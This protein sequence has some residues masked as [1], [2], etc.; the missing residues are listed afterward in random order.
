MIRIRAA[1]RSPE[2]IAEGL[3]YVCAHVD[4]IRRTLLAGTEADANP[5]DDLLA[6]LRSGT[7]PV[8]L[9]ED[10]HHALRRAQDAPGIFGH[11]SHRGTL[12]AAGVNS[13]TRAM[14]I[15]LC[16]RD[17]NP[18]IRHQWPAEGDSP[19]CDVT[20]QPLRRASLPS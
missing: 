6:A 18:C 9:L 14:P 3:A 7:D 4:E 13:T 11:C 17:L 19:T 5:I 8:P 12:T 1:R 20:G 15:L 16:P 2:Q 10:L